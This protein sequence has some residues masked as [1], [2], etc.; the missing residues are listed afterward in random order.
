MILALDMKIEQE[1]K[2]WTTG[3]Q[4]PRHF[5]YDYRPPA[6]G[7]LIVAAPTVEGGAPWQVKGGRTAPLSS[8]RDVRTR[9]W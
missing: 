1:F 5:A 8:H 7:L 9:N 2:K 4:I 3:L 6:E